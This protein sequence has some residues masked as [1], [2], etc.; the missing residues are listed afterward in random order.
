M[1][2]SCWN[3]QTHEND[4]KLYFGKTEI[5]S[6]SV[7]ANLRG[8]EKNSKNIRHTSAYNF[9]HWNLFFDLQK[10]DI[11]FMPC[12]VAWFFKNN[13]LAGRIRHFKKY[14]WKDEDFEVVRTR[15]CSENVVR[16]RDWC[17]WPSSPHMTSLS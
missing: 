7:M 17:G 8:Y 15:K 2:I 9:P 11:S 10:F 5:S 4:V 1:I 13:V 14:Y 6:A 16:N 12:N 3:L